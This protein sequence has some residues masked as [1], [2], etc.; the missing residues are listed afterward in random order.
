MFS[1]LFIN[2][3]KNIIYYQRKLFTN[4]LN[5]NTINY[6]LFFLFI[7]TYLLEKT[8]KYYEYLVN[9]YSPILGMYNII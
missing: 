3:D 8:Q 7:F 1:L 6:I 2:K 4:S 5:S 9:T